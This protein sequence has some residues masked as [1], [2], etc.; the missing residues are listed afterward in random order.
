VALYTMSSSQFRFIYL[1]NLRTSAG[2]KA[3]GMPAI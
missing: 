1:A 3:A 2:K